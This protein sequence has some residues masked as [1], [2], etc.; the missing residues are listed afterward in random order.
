MKLWL[1]LVSIH[2]SLYFILLLIF[3]YL[4]GSKGNDARVMLTAVTNRNEKNNN[5]Q[6][7]HQLML[8]WWLGY[9]SILDILADCVWN[10]LEITHC[11][12]KDYAENQIKL[13]GS[14]IAHLQIGCKCFIV[15]RI[16]L[17]GF[18]IICVFSL[19]VFEDFNKT[20]IDFPECDSRNEFYT[21]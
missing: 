18:I 10:A 4:F 21:C 8:S 19:W 9:I 3:F 5:I 16:V 15:L 11:R 17:R 7:G 20:W 14:K 12:R 13:L 1:I 6:A 2:L